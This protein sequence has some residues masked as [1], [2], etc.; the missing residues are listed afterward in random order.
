MND[1]GV[2]Q[3]ARLVLVGLAIE[4]VIARE[5]I[6]RPLQLPLAD[7]LAQDAG[8]DRGCGPACKAS[9]G[10]L[11]E[12]YDGAPPDVLL[13]ARPKGIRIKSPHNLCCRNG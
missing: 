7:W 6:L 13:V 12:G 10:V 11:L 5:L 1:D 2:R 3:D 4:N 8:T 9:R